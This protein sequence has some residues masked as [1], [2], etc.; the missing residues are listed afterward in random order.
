MKHSKD[1]ELKGGKQKRKREERWRGSC[2]RCHWCPYLPGIPHSGLGPVLWAP[3]LSPC[4]WQPALPE[5]P[6]ASDGWEWRI[7]GPIPHFSAGTIRGESCT[8]SQRSPVGLNLSC[9]PQNLLNNHPLPFILWL[10]SPPA[11][12]CSPAGASWIHLPSKLLAPHIF[13]S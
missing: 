11:L 6:S 7:N 3:H 8:A 2:S 12:T 1:L 5:R 4:R 13:V 9:P 10:P